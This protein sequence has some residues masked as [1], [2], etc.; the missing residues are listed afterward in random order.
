M[1]TT[2]LRITGMDC[3]DCAMTLE[4]AIGRMKG[5]QQCR[6]NF[7]TGKMHIDG[8]PDAAAVKSQIEVLGYGIAEKVQPIKTR[9]SGWRGFLSFMLDRRETTVVM[10]GIVLLALSLTGKAI[11]APAILVH[12]MELAI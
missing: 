3:A 10:I 4:K 11:D 2:E 9:P 5:V 8:A 12:G 7:T 6:V 1:T